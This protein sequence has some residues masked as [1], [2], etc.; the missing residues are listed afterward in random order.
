M[1]DMVLLQGFIHEQISSSR[2]GS[3]A[4]YNTFSSTYECSCKAAR[5]S[6]TMRCFA[7]FSVAAFKLLEEF[8]HF[9]MVLTERA[10]HSAAVCLPWFPSRTYILPYHR[11][12]LML[13]FTVPS[14][15]FKPHT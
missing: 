12:T 2:A 10:Q 15:Q 11:H 4:G 9:L 6:S 1:H 8:L 7:P 3:K 13:Y 14:R 5:A